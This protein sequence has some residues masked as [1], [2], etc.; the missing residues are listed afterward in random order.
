Q[1][2]RPEYKLLGQ[3]PSETTA[4][5]YRFEVKVAADGVEKF[6]VAEERVYDTTMAVSSITPEVL[7]DWVQNK[8]LSDT[9][10]RQLQQIAS[11]KRQIA[12]FDNQIRQIDGN[13]STL[14][15]DQNR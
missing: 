6:P 7:L 15:T 4:N 3:K 5:A 9:G 13:V 10:R 11:V 14:V 8:A 1:T 2:Q 12:D